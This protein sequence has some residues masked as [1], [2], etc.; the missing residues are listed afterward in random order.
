GGGGGGCGGGGG[1]VLGG[2]RPADGQLAVA[3]LLLRSVPPDDPRVGD[4]LQAL[5]GGLG[6]SG[7]IDRLRELEQ[8]SGRHPAVEAACARIEQRL[9]MAC[10]RCERQMRR[11]DMIRPPWE[12]HRLVLAG[13]PAA[14]PA[15]G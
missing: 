9:L 2:G 13:R 7:S 4:F 3:A 8:R 14:G 10:P 12:G 15:G 1:W 5:I 11:P 6:R